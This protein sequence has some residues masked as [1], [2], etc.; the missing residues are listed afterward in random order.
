MTAPTASKRPVGSGV[1]ALP[2]KVT[3]YGQYGEY[4]GHAFVTCDPKGLGR[5]VCDGFL[6]DMTWIVQ[7]HNAV[8]ANT[9]RTRIARRLLRLP[10]AK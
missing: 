8:I 7:L 3:E 5:S 6:D 9:W 4:D 10:E 2:W 1:P